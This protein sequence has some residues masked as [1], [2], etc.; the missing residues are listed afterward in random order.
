M[1]NTLGAALKGCIVKEYLFFEKLNFVMS[2]VGN[3]TYDSNDLRQP[4]PTSSDL[5]P[6]S[7]D[8]LQ[9]PPTSSGFS[10]LLQ[11]S[12]LHFHV[13]LQTFKL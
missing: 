6:T 10:N 4:P 3:R 8:L 5:L 1:R 12:N 7:S 13:K 11:P 9:S 2:F